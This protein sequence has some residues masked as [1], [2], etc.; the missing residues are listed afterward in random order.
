MIASKEMLVQVKVVWNMAGSSLAHIKMHDAL[1]IKK[2]SL[3]TQLQGSIPLALLFKN[4]CP[5]L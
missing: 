3:T 4:A 1:P 5:C 2:N